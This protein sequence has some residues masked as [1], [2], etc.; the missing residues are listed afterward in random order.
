MCRKML[1]T[2]LIT[3]S[4]KSKSSAAQ[5]TTNPK[6]LK[7]QTK[8]NMKEARM[9]TLETSRKR[10]QM[11]RCKKRFL[12]RSW[13]H[14]TTVNTQKWSSNLLTHIV[15]CKHYQS[16]HHKLLNAFWQIF[17]SSLQTAQ[18]DSIVDQRLV[19]LILQMSSPDSKSSF[20]F[21]S[22][23]FKL[24]LIQCLSLSLRAINQL[25]STTLR[26]SHRISSNKKMTM[27][28]RSPTVE[29][30]LR[31]LSLH[32]DKAKRRTKNRNKP[33]DTIWTICTNFRS[34]WWKWRTSYD[35][36]VI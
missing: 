20:L 2:Y 1:R 35:Q 21:H 4:R 8:L 31:L 10:S 25:S 30:P 5:K 7:T 29:W 9:L 19:I 32:L 26:F 12:T 17:H 28:K 16:R 33:F 27:P 6:S 11:K 24:L 15:F 3:S 14:S 13:D 23:M 34:K 22:H 36:K 18:Q